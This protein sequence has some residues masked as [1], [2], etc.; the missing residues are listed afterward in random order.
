M[1]QLQQQERPDFLQ[2]I[3]QL[4]HLERTRPAG[5]Q[6]VVDLIN[7]NW[8]NY[9]LPP[10][11]Q[12]AILGELLSRFAQREFIDNEEWANALSRLGLVDI[13]ALQ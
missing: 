2:H 8:R 3:A 5:L 12:Q 4:N 6:D 11:V 9:V 13:T 7:V 1:A 10:E